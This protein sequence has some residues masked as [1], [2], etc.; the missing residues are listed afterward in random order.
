[1]CKLLAF[2]SFNSASLDPK[3]RIFGKIQTGTTF[4]RNSTVAEDLE[5]EF[6]HYLR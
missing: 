6:Y 4:L 1:M 3:I 5:P 2:T